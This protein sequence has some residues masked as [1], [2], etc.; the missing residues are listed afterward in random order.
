MRRLR[1]LF[2]YADCY[3]IIHA[4][5]IEGKNEKRDDVEKGVLAKIPETFR[6]VWGPIEQRILGI[7][8]NLLSGQKANSI[9]EATRDTTLKIMMPLS[10]SAWYYLEEK[11]IENDIRASGVT[12]ENFGNPESRKA[13]MYLPGQ[14]DYNIHERM[15][16]ISKLPI[17]RPLRALEN[18]VNHLPPTI[19]HEFME[20][21]IEGQ[22]N[23][24]EDAQYRFVAAD[25]LYSAR[26][27]DRVQEILEE[28][29]SY[30]RTLLDEH[31]SNTLILVGYSFGG[32]MGKELADRLAVDYPGRIG[33]VAHNSPF[34]PEKGE[35]V[36]YAKLKDV[37]EKI[38][39]SEI[40]DGSL[41]PAYLLSGI[42]DWISTGDSGL[43]NKKDGKEIIP[44]RI[45]ANHTDPCRSPIATRYIRAAIH[46]A[47]SRLNQGPPFE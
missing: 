22:D 35:F 7:L 38:G 41:F 29:E 10:T 20:L 5:G 47:Q 19:N 4:M 18:M 24:A 2:T 33:L 43:I 11:G 12:F 13:V 46:R 34:D 25:T 31:P 16:R 42:D 36:K 8:H 17:V 30:A 9:Y 28:T 27:L 3:I 14:F 39:F 40:Y 26:R 23:T 37:H 21:L 15:A 6:K 1:R 32:L 44:K 45:P